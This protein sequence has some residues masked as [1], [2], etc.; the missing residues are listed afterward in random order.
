[1]I[2]I[3]AR[4]LSLFVSLLCWVLLSVLTVYIIRSMRESARLVRDNENERLFN[5]L[6]TGLRDYDDFGSAIEDNPALG[7][8]ITGF[9][10]YGNDLHL[11]YSWG[12]VPSVFDEDILDNLNSQ[13][14]YGRYTIPDETSLSVKFIIQTE[15]WGMIPGAQMPSPG[16]Q[17][18]PS[19]A[20]TPPSGAQ[21]Q[22]SVAGRQQNRSGIMRQGFPFFNTLA[23]G[24]YYYVDIF[25]PAYWRTITYTNLLLPVCCILLLALVLYVR[26]LYLR[27]REYRE[28]IEAQKN[29]VI[30]GTAAGTLAHEIKNPLSSI[31]LQTGILVKLCLENGREEVAIINEEVDRLSALCHRVS[32]YLRD[33]KGSPEPVK[34]RVL[35]T[36][37]GMRLCARDILGAGLNEGREIQVL[38]DP[39]RLRSVLEN[40]I[41]NALESGSPPQNIEASLR[42]G[43]KFGGRIIISILD[44]G[45]GIAKEDQSRLFDL[46]FTRKSRGTGI[47][48][49]ICKRFVDAAGGSISLENREGGGAEARVILSEFIPPEIS[50]DESV[51]HTGEHALTNS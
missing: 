16:P 48:L 34:L 3:S 46:F 1:M 49:S 38:A 4:T 9:A 50:S 13:D 23:R 7:E 42:G 40:L 19:R 11:L 31:R 22:S 15:G 35:L 2:K 45:K 20:Q 33:S 32:D 44:R 24:R 5:V 26:F 37:V 14:R 17:A 18:Q 30:L 8:R 47:G 51:I 27:N 41:R 39:D 25:H 28:R 10:I 6:F 29:L 43:A 36:E 12:K 21:T